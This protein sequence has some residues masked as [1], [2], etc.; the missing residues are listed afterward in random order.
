MSPEVLIYIQTVKN[1]F[2]KNIEAKDYFL[3]N[4]DEKIFFKYLAEISEKNFKT[5]G[6]VALSVDQFELLKR[7]V[8]AISISKKTEE[9]LDNSHLFFKVKD[10]GFF[11]L[12]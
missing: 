12:N 1:F 9:E 2:E 4:L 5:N 6:E 8:I 7:T 11:S 3:K 10:Y